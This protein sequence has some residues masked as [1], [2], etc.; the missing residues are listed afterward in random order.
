MFGEA[1]FRL[2]WSPNRVTSRGGKWS[3]WSRSV[4]AAD[5]GTLVRLPSGILVPNGYKPL[6]SVIEV[7][8][9]RKYAFDAGWVLER[10]IPANYYGARADWEARVVPGTSIPLS[11][12]YPMHGDFE[13]CHN[14]ASI[15]VPSISEL[16]R[17]IESCEKARSEHKT[18]TAQVLLERNN[19]AMREFE[20]E[21]RKD[22]EESEAFVREIMQT[23]YSTSLQMGAHRT[24]MAAAMGIREHVGN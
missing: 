23:N 7:R 10:W 6:R 16:Q 17:A 21:S 18:N 5:R 19:A 2:V 3:D 9:I 14:S 11:G 1:N 20:E 15:E 8:T 13:M 22:R 24:R 12:P 4:A